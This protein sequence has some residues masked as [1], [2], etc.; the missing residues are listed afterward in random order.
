MRSSVATTRAAPVTG[1]NWYA[2]SSMKKRP[3]NPRSGGAPIIAKPPT[4]KARPA[5]GARRAVGRSG[6]LRRSSVP[7]ARSWPDADAPVTITLAR[8]PMIPGPERVAIPT[9]AAPRFEI[10][11]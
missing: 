8:A 2:M 5:S 7:A 1:A 10:T 6:A 11:E 4:T 9:S 3:G